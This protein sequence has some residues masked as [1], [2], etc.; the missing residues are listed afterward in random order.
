MRDEAIII[1][2]AVVTIIGAY[3]FYEISAEQFI[4]VQVALIM[5]PS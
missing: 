3:I 4:T 2:I 1:A 5:P